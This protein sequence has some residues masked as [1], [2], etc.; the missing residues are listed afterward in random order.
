MNK[1][2]FA[3]MVL[4]VTASSSLAQRENVTSFST[5]SEKDIRDHF[6]LIEITDP[7]RFH[8]RYFRDHYP[9]MQ[10]DDKIVRDFRWRIYTPDAS[11][12]NIYWAH[13]I[14]PSDGYPTTNRALIPRPLPAGPADIVLIVHANANEGGSFRCMMYPE[15]KS[16]NGAS[17]QGFGTKNAEWIPY[18]GKVECVEENPPRDKTTEFDLD[19][20]FTIMKHYTINAQMEYVGFMIWMEQCDWKDR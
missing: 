3:I 17:H 18:Y 4:F 15:Y 19:E 16:H 10:S 14:L 9:G 7:S 5:S 1:L 20:K 12:V 8:I 11:S 2:C 13:G 6:G